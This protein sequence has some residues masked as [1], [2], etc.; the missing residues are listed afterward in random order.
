MLLKTHYKYVFNYYKH[1]LPI[2]FVPGGLIILHRKHPLPPVISKYSCPLITKLISRKRL[3]S[4]INTV[5]PVRNVHLPE[6][7]IAPIMLECSTC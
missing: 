3:K 4:N 5:T 7:I 1:M 6:S 2:Q